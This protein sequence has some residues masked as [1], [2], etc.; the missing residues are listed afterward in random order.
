MAGRLGV[1][2]DSDRLGARGEQR[3]RPRCSEQEEG[4]RRLQVARRVVF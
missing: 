2:E 3:K 4:G 1:S